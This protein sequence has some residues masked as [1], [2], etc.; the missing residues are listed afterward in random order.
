MSAQLRLLEAGESHTGGV[1][2]P[3]R[4]ERRRRGTRLRRLL[5]DTFLPVGYPASVRAGYLEYQVWDMIQGLCTYLRFTLAIRALLSGLGVGNAAASVVSGTLLWAAKDGASMFA[6]LVFS[7]AT[8][9]EIGLNIRQ[10]RL[11]ADVA[12]DV[13][14]LLQVLAPSFGPRGFAAATCA[15]SIV[16]ALCGVAA[17]ASKTSISEHFA[18]HS[19]ADVVTK[20]GA[21]ETGVQLLGLAGGAVLLRWLGPA[22]SSTSPARLWGVFSALTAAHLYSSLRAVRSLQFTRPNDVRLGLLLAASRTPDGDLS[23]STV[24]ATEPRLPPRL[25]APRVR[26]GA[27][28]A[29]AVAAV[30]AA[31]LAAAIGRARAAGDRFAVA[32]AGKGIARTAFVLLGP[33]VDGEALLRARY[34]AEVALE[35]AAGLLLEEGASLRRWDEFL[36]TLKKNGWETDRPLLRVE[37]WRYDFTEEPVWNGPEDVPKGDMS[38]EGQTT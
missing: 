1:V 13:M 19:L 23:V 35:E 26:L 20:E 27:R 16:G 2:P 18:L 10:W 38:F 5:A 36:Q 33:S 24:S 11:L 8:A 12:N 14:L 31:P 28:L 7:W 21:Q 17:R 4:K 34:A 9:A 32:V 15:S 37:P 6:T 22:A 29:D 30:G 25:R 3:P